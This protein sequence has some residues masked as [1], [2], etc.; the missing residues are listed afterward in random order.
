MMRP[1]SPRRLARTVGEVALSVAALLG[2]V[3]V[4]VAIAATVFGITPLV[5]RS[6]SMSPTITTGSLALAN[7]VPAD[8]L[9]V[10]DVVSVPWHGTR[11]THRVVA[12]HHDG[13]ATELSMKGDANQV[14]DPAPYSVG[15]ADRVFAHVPDLGYAVAWTTSRSGMFT[16]GVVLAALVGVIVWPRRRTDDSKVRPATAVGMAVLM[17]AVAAGAGA[18][19]RSPRTWAYWTDTSK[20][21]TGGFVA[22]ALNPPTNMSCS[23][24]GLLSD[25]TLSWTAPAGGVTPNQYTVTYRAGSA[26]AAP[27]TT[28][29]T[30]TSW[31]V[32]NSLLSL[33]TTYYVSVQSSLSGTNWVS[34]SANPGQKVQVTSVIG[35][36]ALTSCS[37]SFTPT[38]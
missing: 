4:L 23:G 27:T 11:V 17:L 37:G 30:S 3:C 1:P 9:H 6:G 35:V 34:A 12:I 22:G 20:V 38:S 10:G 25:P 19:A 5:F 8:Q 32:P 7:R 2:V 21:T 14:A 13:R 26:T 28:T 29:T 33:L 18:I 36:G 15:S 31:Q 24:A 16:G